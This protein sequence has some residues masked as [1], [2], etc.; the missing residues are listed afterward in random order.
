MGKELVREQLHVFIDDVESFIHQ[1]FRPWGVFGFRGLPGNGILRILLRPVI[2]HEVNK[3]KIALQNQFNTIL[4][5]AEEIDKKG[6][7]NVDFGKYY[8]RMLESELLYQHYIGDRKEEFE[9]DIKERLDGAA[10][11]IAP[12]IDTEADDFWRALVEAYDR[13]EAYELFQYHFR[14]Y[15]RLMDK[16]GADEIELKTDTLIPLNYTKEAERTYPEA[17]KMVRERLI[18]GYDEEYEKQAMSKEEEMRKENEE[19]KKHVEEL[20]EENQELEELI[21]ELEK[22]NEELRAQTDEAR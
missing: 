11:D 21:E 14:Y 2:A 12:L 7:E 8:D 17:E 20:E 22:E 9:Q 15:E 13:D 3:V 6:K 1:N 10:E 16:Y 19:L 4:D 5:A 18:E